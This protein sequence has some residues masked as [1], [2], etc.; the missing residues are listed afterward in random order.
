MKQNLNSNISSL[1]L[2]F[3]CSLQNHWQTNNSQ[4]IQRKQP[5][6]LFFSLAP[7][8]HSKFISSGMQKPI[9]I[10]IIIF[11]RRG[12]HYVKNALKITFF[13]LTEWQKQKQG[14]FLITLAETHIQVYSDDKRLEMTFSKWLLSFYT[15]FLLGIVGID[16]YK[17]GKFLRTA[18]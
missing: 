2:H 12:Q 13:L 9:I 14:H 5:A 6:V 18:S 8:S 17:M 16:A 4:H 1:M 3:W 11:Y 10:I 15:S 7:N